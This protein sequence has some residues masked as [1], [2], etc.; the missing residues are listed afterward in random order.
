MLDTHPMVDAVVVSFHLGPKRLHSVDVRQFVDKLAD[1]ILDHFV[2]V[3]L[4]IRVTL[5]VIR[6]DV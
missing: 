3:S 5:E 2:I 4:K 6:I 1:T